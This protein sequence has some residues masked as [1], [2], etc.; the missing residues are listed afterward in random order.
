MVDPQGFTHYPSLRGLS[1]IS[2]DINDSQ[3]RGFVRLSSIGS[4]QGEDVL[5]CCILTPAANAACLQGSTIQGPVVPIELFA[6]G[7]EDFV[8][9]TG[10]DLVVTLQA[11]ATIQ[12][13]AQLEYTIR[14]DNE[15]PA[16]A[17]GARVREYFNLLS[18]NPPALTT[19]LWTCLAS[20]AGSSCSSSGGN[21]VISS[22]SEQS[23]NIGVGGSITFTVT[24]TVI[25]NPMPTPG[26]QL[27]L[28]AAA[29]SRPADNES[30]IGNN[31][32]EVL[33][34]IQSPSVSASR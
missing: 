5:A 11:P 14:I 1:S 26:S 9:Q 30:R 10:P 27:R 4:G 13:G 19:G 31:Q 29:F 7:F 33:V 25:A 16:A 20:G 8:P 17:T 21:G 32:G 23:L 3:S 24:R 22:P 6:D 34:T 15:G 12:A 28:Q 2:Y 18:A